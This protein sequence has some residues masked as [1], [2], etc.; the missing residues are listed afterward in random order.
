MKKATRV[1]YLIIGVIFPIF[2]GLLHTYVHFTDL[3]T[4]TVQETLNTNLIISGNPQTYWNTWGVVSFMMGWAFIVIGLLNIVLF[5]LMKKEDYP[6]V[7][8]FIVMGLY[9]F[10]VIYVGLE[11]NAIPQLYGAFFGL[12]LIF[13]GLILTLKGKRI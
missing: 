7:M 4:V 9:L 12:I 1:I 13:A 11:F 5:S 2:I 6:P 8:G 10:G 3:T